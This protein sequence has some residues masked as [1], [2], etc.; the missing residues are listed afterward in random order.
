VIGAFSSRAGS[1]SPGTGATCWR[2]LEVLAPELGWAL[3]HLSS[4]PVFPPAA[5]R[6]PYGQ[7]LCLASYGRGHLESFVWPSSWP[8]SCLWLLGEAGPGHDV[9]VPGGVLSFPPHSIPCNFCALCSLPAAMGQCP[10]Q[11]SPDSGGAGGR[12]SCWS[13]SQS[14]VWCSDFLSWRW[15]LRSQPREWGRTPGLEKEGSV[16]SSSPTPTPGDRV[17]LC[18]LP[19]SRH[20]PALGSWDKE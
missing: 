10:W 16:P 4:A 8:A 5:L 20:S 9:G 11:A 18:P 15:A 12:I 14:E 19:P 2:A 7:E 3:L 1:Q 13:H 17:S 6:G